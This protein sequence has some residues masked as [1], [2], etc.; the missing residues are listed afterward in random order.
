MKQ[1]IL[2][3][4]FIASLFVLFGCTAE[5]P[6]TTNDLIKLKQQ[7]SVEEAFSPNL[8]IMN[9]YI[10][11]LALLRSKSNF[12]LSSVIDAEMNSAQSFYYFTKALDESSAMQYTGSICNSLEYKNVLD[13]L[14][15]AI[16]Y[17]NKASSALTVVSPTEAYLLRENQ[18]EIVSSYNSFSKEMKDSLLDLC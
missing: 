13:Y 10:S 2:L 11:E 1:I 16:S 5:S 12:P 4:I 6:T 7:Y 18:A 14:D 9:S 15:L 8:D 17:A 3:V